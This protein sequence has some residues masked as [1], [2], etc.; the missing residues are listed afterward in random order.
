MRKLKSTVNVFVTFVVT[1]TQS[2]HCW[3]FC[4]WLLYKT[5]GFQMF[6][7]KASSQ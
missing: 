4:I 1:V 3:M 2:Q 7:K 5:S 6:T